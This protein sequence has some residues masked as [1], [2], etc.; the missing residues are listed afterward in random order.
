MKWA[1]GMTLAGDIL[2]MGL[3]PAAE[4]APDGSGFRNLLSLRWPHALDP[5]SAR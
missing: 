4:V 3:H 1:R 5:L 2:G